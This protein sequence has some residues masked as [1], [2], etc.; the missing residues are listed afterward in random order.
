VFFFVLQ[1]KKKATLSSPSFL[2]SCTALRISLQRYS[3]MKKAMAAMPSPSLCLLRCA[4][5]L[6]QSNEKGDD[7]CRRLFFF[8]FALLCCATLQRRRR[9]HCCHRLLLLVVQLHRNS[10]K[11]AMVAV[12]RRLLLPIVELRY[13]STK[14]ATT[15]TPS[16]SSSLLP[17]VV[18]QHCGAMVQRSTALQGSTMLCCNAAEHSV[19]A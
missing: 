6:L 15:A 18:A 4:G 1:E 16:P 2:F 19:A 3:A 14:K 12:C 10:T 8:F 17:Y 9:W 13:S 7:S 11:K 5:A